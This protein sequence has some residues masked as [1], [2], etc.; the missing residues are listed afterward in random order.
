MTIIASS[1]GA[2]AAGT[3]GAM[4]SLSAFA[5]YLLV[6]S[7]LFSAFSSASAGKKK[8][9]A[10]RRAAIAG[11]TT[12]RLRE[13]GM[14]LQQDSALSTIRA[15][16][17]ATGVDIGQG[18]AMQAYLQT[19]RETELEI[20]MAHRVA[21]ANFAARLSGASDDEAEGNQKAFGSLLGGAADMF[22][23]KSKKDRATFKA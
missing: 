16:A 23:Y 17:G 3:G 2:G 12:D 4:A 10:G 9:A 21:D 11:L 22:S 14:K 5:P 8:A 7:T 1:A 19:A 13:R 18:S 20:V 6:A 15:N